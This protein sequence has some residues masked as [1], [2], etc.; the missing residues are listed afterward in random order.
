MRYK[1]NSPTY[2]EYAPTKTLIASCVQNLSAADPITYQTTYEVGS[3]CPAIFHCVLNGIDNGTM[4]NYA[5]GSTI[6]G[7]IPTILSMIGTSRDDHLRIHKQF[8]ILALLLSACNPST[9]IS[10][11]A[12]RTNTPPEDVLSSRVQIDTYRRGKI[13][14]VVI[15]GIAMAAAGLTIWQ[16]VVLG[17][18][19]VVAFACPTWYNPLLW[20]LLGPV[21]H[22]IDFTTSRWCIESRHRWSWNL[23]VLDELKVG[24]SWVMRWKDMILTILALAQYIYGTVILSSMQL[25]APRPALQIAVLFALPAIF[26]KL[27]SVFLLELGPQDHKDSARKPEHTLGIRE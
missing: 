19:G 16:A 23:S 5:A 4:A 18:R 8:P 1:F 21:A 7:F 20:V 22:I 17:M 10:G 25:V 24:W 14:A 13:I 6:L 27:V 11:L 12:W 9:I 2:A 3:I 15:H 26:A